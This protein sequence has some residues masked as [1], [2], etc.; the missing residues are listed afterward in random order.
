MLDIER[1]RLT[2]ETARRLLNEAMPEPSLEKGAV[3]S[4]ICDLLELVDEL[5]SYIRDKHELIKEL[6]GKTHE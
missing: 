3:Y 5:E 6:R 2:K 4:F 1:K